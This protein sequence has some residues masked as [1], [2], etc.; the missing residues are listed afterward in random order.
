MRAEETCP[1][2]GLLKRKK[3]KAHVIINKLKNNAGRDVHLA[4]SVLFPTISLVKG[5]FSIFYAVFYIR[6]TINHIAPIS[7]VRY[8]PRT[9][10]L[11]LSPGNA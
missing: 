10:I 4:D 1:T 11:A 9:M 3:E 5:V 7:N 6:S 2:S 8:G